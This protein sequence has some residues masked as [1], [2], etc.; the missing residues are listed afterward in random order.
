MDGDGWQE[1]RELPPSS[2][3]TPG[4][5]G[6]KQVQKYKKMLLGTRIHIKAI[7]PLSNSV[8]CFPNIELHS[9]NIELLSFT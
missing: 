4:V 8:L 7:A 9:L 3:D 1:G 6:N 5:E 2:Q